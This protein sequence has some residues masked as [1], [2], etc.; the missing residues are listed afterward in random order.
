MA[1]MQIINYLNGI[2]EERRANPRDDLLSALLA[3]EEEGEKLNEEELRTT[4]VLLF[5]AGHET[6]TNL[7]GNGTV[8]LLRNR[9]QWDRLVADPSLA[10]SAEEELL[11]Y[12]GPVHPT[13]RTAPVP[14]AVGGG[15]VEPGQGENGRA[16][17]RER[18]CP[19]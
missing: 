12:D 19:E 13:A 11:R 16:S 6:T 2:F 8:A 4:V 10:P 5:I 17:G 3:A 9:D 7:I 14:S 1:F 18:G 15:E